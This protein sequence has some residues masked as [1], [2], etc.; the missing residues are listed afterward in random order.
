MTGGSIRVRTVAKKIVRRFG[1]LALEVSDSNI[2]EDWTLYIYHIILRYI[3]IDIK[4]TQEPPKK[5]ISSDFISTN[6]ICV[7][8]FAT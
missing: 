8:L 2:M 3:H 7:Q 4:I 5:S 1:N 6:Q